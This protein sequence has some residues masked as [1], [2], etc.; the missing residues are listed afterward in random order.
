MTDLHPT[1]RTVPFAYGSLVLFNQWREA[2]PSSRFLVS[3]TLRSGQQFY[4]LGFQFNVNDKFPGCLLMLGEP[5]GT[6]RAFAVRDEDIAHVAFDPIPE[7]KDDEPTPFGFAA[8]TQ[9]KA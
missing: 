5:E 8:H 7:Q 6:Q 4:S 3:T 1:L 2:E 9:R